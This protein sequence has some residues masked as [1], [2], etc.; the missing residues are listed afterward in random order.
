VNSWMAME[1][2]IGQIAKENLPGQPRIIVH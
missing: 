2:I 1:W